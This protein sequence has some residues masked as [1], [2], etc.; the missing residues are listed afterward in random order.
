MNWFELIRGQTFWE[1]VFF[2]DI[3]I[4]IY[5]YSYTHYLYIS[6]YLSHMHILYWAWS[7]CVRWCSQHLSNVHIC[8]CMVLKNTC[9]C[10]PTLRKN[11]YGL[12]HVHLCKR[13]SSFF[14][15]EA[16]ANL[17]WVL[18]EHHAGCL[19]PPAL[20]PLTGGPALL[21]PPALLP[22]SCSPVLDAARFKNPSKSTPA[23]VAVAAA[24]LHK[25]HLI[26][27]VGAG[28]IQFVC[29]SRSHFAN[30]GYPSQ[31]CV[32][33]IFTRGF[34]YVYDIYICI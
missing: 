7:K 8:T 24:V 34:V 18:R 20:L 14:V 4:Y 5:I 27:R 29:G 33:A 16:I 1:V 17:S 12:V 28:L 3:Q 13:C 26:I 25:H 15:M 9:E 31:K 32:V 10:M 21:R 11:A 6:L 2:T 19:W 22:P 30:G 23:H